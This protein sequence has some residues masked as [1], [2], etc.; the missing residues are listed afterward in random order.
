MNYIYDGSWEGFLTAIFDAYPHLDSVEAI[1][2]PDNQLSIIAQEIQVQ[3]D[4]DKARRV[5]K[6]ICQTF[7]KDVYQDVQCVF[8]SCRK[9]KELVA[10]RVLKKMYQQGKSYLYSTDA[11]V[12]FFHEAVKNVKNEAH[13]YLGVLR[14]EEMDGGVLLGKM[15]PKNHVLPLVAQH[16]RRRMPQEQFIVADVQRKIAYVHQKGKGNVF[17]YEE[18]FSRQAQGEEEYQQLWKTFYHHVSIP[19]RFNPK[20]QQSN[21]PKKYWKHMTEFSR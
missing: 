7:G 4:E 1:Q 18:L 20:L 13:T 15:S 10:A 5:A 17:M 9:K 12:L 8:Y 14:F 6:W 16:F 19:Q 11:D 21:L 2:V 3:S